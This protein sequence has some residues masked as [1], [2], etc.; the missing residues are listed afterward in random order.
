M[1]VLSIQKVCYNLFVNEDVFEE[2]IMNAGLQK[3]VDQNFMTSAQGDYIEKAVMNKEIIIV[4][5]HK[6]WG[7]LPLLATIGNMAK[8]HHSVKQVKGF[9]C[10]DD[11]ADYYVIAS[12]KE[13]DFE[14]LVT[15]AFSSGSTRTI[16][17]KDPDHPYS[18]MKTIKD[19]YKTTGN[20]E[21]VYHVIEC[22]KIDD[23]KKLA[24]IKCMV[25]DTSGKLKKTEG[26]S[27]NE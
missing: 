23:E 12:P 8:Q 19:V 24:S 6:G 14:A 25:M 20:A 11:S 13:T 26:P 1:S 10:L 2:E 4:S 18:I 15:K 22:A 21:K 27:I 16:T 9:D 5:G 7:I 17:L 3:L